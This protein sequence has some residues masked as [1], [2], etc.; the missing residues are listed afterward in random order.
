MSGESPPSITI[1]F[2]H[3]GS[4]AID[5]RNFHLLQTFDSTSRHVTSGV[6]E[7]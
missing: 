7:E 1:V 5:P 6:T 4:L 3:F 2:R